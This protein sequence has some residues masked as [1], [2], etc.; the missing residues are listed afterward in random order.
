MKV[1]NRI[2]INTLECSIFTLFLILNLN[3]F[4]FCYVVNH[5]YDEVLSLILNIFAL[6]GDNC[7]NFNID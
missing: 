3:I 2:L 1:L 4:L 7:A 5:F 6:I